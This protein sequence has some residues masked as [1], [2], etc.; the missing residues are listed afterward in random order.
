M[1]STTN[2]T[3]AT[4]FQAAVINTANT[5]LDGTG[6]ITGLITGAN[7]GTLIRN[8]TIKAMQSTS[9]GMIRFFLYDP[10]P[11][12]WFL[13]S[14]IVV[15]QTVQTGVVQSFSTNFSEAICLPSG[16][17]LGV[18]TEVSESFSITAD[19]VSWTNCEC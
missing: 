17:V 8:V 12:A 14:E 9:I 3:F 7:D 18:T 15:P 6:N 1:C 5:N 16:Y 13:Y 2:M 11:G 19:G 4:N 10:G